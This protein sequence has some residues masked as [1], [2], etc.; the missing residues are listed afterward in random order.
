MP[1]REAYAEV[2]EELV[3]TIPLQK[4]G[5]FGLEGSEKLGRKIHVRVLPRNRAPSPCCDAIVPDCSPS[6]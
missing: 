4:A 5:V 2:C 6:A 1:G 3:D